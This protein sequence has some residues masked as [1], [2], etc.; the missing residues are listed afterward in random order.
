MLGAKRQEVGMMGDRFGAPWR[1]L[2][3]VLGR[4]SGRGGRRGV[5]RSRRPEA[6]TSSVRKLRQNTSS[7]LS[8]TSRPRTSRPPSAV[9]QV[10]TTTAI[11][12]TREVLLRTLYPA[13][14]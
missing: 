5:P 4:R 3:R 2:G 10:A 7:S 8:P 6:A 13:G 11:D 14:D 1:Q 12:T 9:I